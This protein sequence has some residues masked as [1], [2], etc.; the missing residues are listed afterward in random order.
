MSKDQ[1]QCSSLAKK[2]ILEMVVVPQH[3]PGKSSMVIPENAGVPVAPHL[4]PAVPARPASDC[5]NKD[6]SWNR[7]KNASLWP[8]ANPEDSA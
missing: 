7:G 4:P 5:D 8:D 6:S 3:M 2:T 1:C